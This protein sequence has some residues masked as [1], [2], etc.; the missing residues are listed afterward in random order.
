LISSELPTGFS[1]LGATLLALA[2]KHITANAINTPATM[3]YDIGAS[4][5]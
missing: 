4:I 3:A 2:A 5:E 1:F